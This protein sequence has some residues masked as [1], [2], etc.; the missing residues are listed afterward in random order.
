[1]LCVSAFR[2]CQTRSRHCVASSRLAVK[3]ECPLRGR[4]P[5]LGDSSSSSSKINT[6]QN[7]SFLKCTSSG[8]YACLCTCPPGKYFNFV[9]HKCGRLKFINKL[10]ALQAQQTRPKHQHTV[11]EGNPSHNTDSH[12]QKDINVIKYNGSKHKN[13]SIHHLDSN[14]LVPSNVNADLVLE[15]EQTSDSDIDESSDVVGEGF[16]LEDDSLFPAWAIALVVLCLVIVL[17]SVVLILY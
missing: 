1:M 17:V 3:F 15:S 10:D 4:F 8:L 14:A 6:D 9:D 5:V 12:F 11:L 13:M 2:D 7:T 16:V